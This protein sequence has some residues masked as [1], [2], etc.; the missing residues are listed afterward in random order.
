[1]KQP[2]PSLTMI[3]ITNDASMKKAYSSEIPVSAGLTC[4]VAAPNDM[5]KNVLWDDGE[6]V[7]SREQFPVVAGQKVLLARLAAEQPMP[8]SLDRLAHEFALKDEL[9]G[10]W[11][12]R[13]LR[14][15][16]EGS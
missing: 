13:P 3:R 10:A 4:L 11:A 8:A 5:K 7:F 16:R 6:R 14:L 2:A 12:V 1:M 9:D 15:V